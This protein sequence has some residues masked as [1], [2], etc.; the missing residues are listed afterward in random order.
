M[1][2]AKVFRQ[3]G[4]PIACLKISVL[5]LL[6]ACHHALASPPSILLPPIAISVLAALRS[7]C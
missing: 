3:L 2:P 1:T 6:D 5:G 4:S 7:T